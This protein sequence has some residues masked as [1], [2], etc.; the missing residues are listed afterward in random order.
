MKGASKEPLFYAL[1]SLSDCASQAGP[2]GDFLFS[3]LLAPLEGF[4]GI[5]F[6]KTTFPV[7]NTGIP[8]SD[9]LSSSL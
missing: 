3:V 8:F 2:K 5:Y 6:I 1:K 9:C 4:G 7:R